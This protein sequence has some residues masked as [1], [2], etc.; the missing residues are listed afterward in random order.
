MTEKRSKVSLKEGWTTVF[1]G[2]G[3]MNHGPRSPARRSGFHTGRR[4][5]FHH[6]LSNV[7]TTVFWDYRRRLIVVSLSSTPVHVPLLSNYLL[8]TPLSSLPS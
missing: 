6:S 4:A 1:V 7:S 3:S 5:D 2:K 8:L